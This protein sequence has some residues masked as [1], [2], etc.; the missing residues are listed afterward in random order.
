MNSLA[1][2]RITEIDKFGSEV[3]DKINIEMSKIISNYKTVDAG[4]AG[5]Q[6]TELSI[7]ANS[8]TNKLSKIGPLASIQ[9]FIGRFDTIENKVEQIISGIENTKNRL[10]IVMDSM[11]YSRECIREYILDFKPLEEQLS[12]YIDELESDTTSDEIR[13]QAVVNR[14]KT[15][16]SSRVTAEQS[17]IETTLLI[18]QTQEIQ[19]QINEMLSN[20]IPIF[21]MKLVNALSI[22]IHNEALELKAQVKKI[23]ERLIV[24]NAKNIE[25]NTDIMIENR[26]SA[27]INP[28][29]LIEANEIL[30]RVVSKAVEAC[31]TETEANKKV[32]DR[33]NSASIMLMSKANKMKLGA[34]NG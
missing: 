28:E 15:L 31:S 6:L 33:L 13:L 18:G 11:T 8:A 9:R 29:T 25:K 19:H 5:Q 21:K 10:N 1:T 30:Q 2:M 32:I 23:S 16:T 7:A 22:K 17:F 27:I 26:R 24:E 3:Q 12:N 4:S 20:I 14:L 34:E